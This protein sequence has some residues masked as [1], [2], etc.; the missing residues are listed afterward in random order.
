MSAIFRA[1]RQNDVPNLKLLIEGGGSIDSKDDEG[2]T[3]LMRGAANGH[4]NIVKCLVGMK[5][6][7]E[8]KDAHYG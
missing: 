4:L 7:L 6:N 1:V 2:W 8:A 3:P 5:A